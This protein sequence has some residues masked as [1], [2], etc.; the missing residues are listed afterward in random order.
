[1]TSMPLHARAY[2][3][4]DYPIIQDWWKRHGVKDVPLGWL[5]EGGVIVE[6]DGKAVAVCWLYLDNS[7][8]VGWLA[9]V[10]TSPDQT[11]FEARRALDFMYEAA[12][13][14]AKSQNR[15][16]FFADAP[17]EALERFYESHGFVRNHPTVHY[18]KE[19]D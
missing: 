8:P 3:P 1:M 19:I 9:W 18:F 6:R 14:V 17:T 4:D 11:P 15:T 10:T 13:A 2:T 16:G 7:C 12:R 5:P